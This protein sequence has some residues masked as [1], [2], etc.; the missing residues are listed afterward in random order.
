MKFTFRTSVTSYKLTPGKNK[1]RWDDGVLE[2]VTCN[3][4]GPAQARNDKKL[5]EEHNVPNKRSQEN[6]Q[7][8]FVI[9]NVRSETRF[10]SWT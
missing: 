8:F 9:L 1:I 2:K 6:F 7:V 4:A 5:K 3:T 10:W